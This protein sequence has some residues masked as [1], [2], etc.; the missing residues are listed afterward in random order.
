MNAVDNISAQFS[1]SGKQES[2]RREVHLSVWWA[3]DS[4]RTVPVPSRMGTDVQTS[5]E[6]KSLRKAGVHGHGRTKVELFTSSSMG[7]LLFSLEWIDAGCGHCG[8][9]GSELPLPH[10]EDDYEWWYERGVR[11]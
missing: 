1:S 3:R 4:G 5:A 11:W 2:T 7:F 9:G 10:M 6:C 8:L